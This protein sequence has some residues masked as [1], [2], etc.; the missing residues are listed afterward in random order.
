VNFWIVGIAAAVA[1]QLY[2]LATRRHVWFGL[3]DAIGEAVRD[4]RDDV[5][6]DKL[7]RELLT[8]YRAMS[9]PALI[10]R[11]DPSADPG[12]AAACLGGPAWLADDEAWPLDDEGRRLEFVVQ[13]DLARLPAIRGLPDSGVARFFVGRD[14]LM[15]ANWNQ[16]DRAGARVLWHDGPM[17]GGRREPQAPL[18]ERDPSPFARGDTREAGRALSPEGI[19]DLPDSESWQVQ[20]LLEALAGRPGIAAAEEAL[21]ELAEAK[22]F[23]HRIGGHP[24][25][26]QPDFRDSGEFAEFDVLLLG[27]TS[28]DLIMWGD[29]GEAMFLISAGDLARRDFSRVAFYWDCH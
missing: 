25:F 21:W 10:L 4:A 7:T 28:D 27:L 17:A 3:K 22:S 23:A 24:S 8:A 29:V 19:D 20:Q 18:D 1:I 16:P 11:P 15:G 14:D 9:R 13:Y 6:A 26:T 2:L 5:E 12:G